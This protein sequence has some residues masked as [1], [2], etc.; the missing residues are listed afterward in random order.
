MAPRL[1]LNFQF[2]CANLLSTGV[3]AISAGPGR[4]MFLY[5]EIISYA[6]IERSGREVASINLSFLILSPIKR[7]FPEM[8]EQSEGEKSSLASDSSLEGALNP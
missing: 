2:F 4:V 5:F 3:S 7:R 6:V 1:V 8:K